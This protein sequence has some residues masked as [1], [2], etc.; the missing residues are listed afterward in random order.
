MRL[1]R[2]GG[3]F[4]SFIPDNITKYILSSSNGR[5]LGS[6]PRGW[7]SNPCERAIPSSTPTQAGMIRLLMSIHSDRATVGSCA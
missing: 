4:E 5:T 1:G 3:R 7:G 2:I 6:G